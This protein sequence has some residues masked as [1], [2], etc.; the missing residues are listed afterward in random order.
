M[1][2]EDKTLELIN[3]E[4]EKIR[5]LWNNFIPDLSGI[6]NNDKKKI[7]Q[8]FQNWAFHFQ[9]FILTGWLT[10]LIER[11]WKVVSNVKKQ[12]CSH[13][14]NG[15]LLTGLDF[16]WCCGI[17]YEYWN[18]ISDRNALDIIISST[19]V[20]DNFLKEIDDIDLILKDLIVKNNESPSFD[21]NHWWNEYLPLGVKEIFICEKK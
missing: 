20:G 12:S 11:Y 5:E 2:T 17:S 16:E 18:D 10:W 6:P 9:R 8:A 4:K 19:F 3:L 13:W 15:E 1:N 21:T 7:Q 14:T